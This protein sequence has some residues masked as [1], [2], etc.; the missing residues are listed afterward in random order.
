MP[1]S[2]SRTHGKTVKRQA[3]AE[4]AERRAARRVAELEP[5]PLPTWYK[6]IMFGLMIIGLLW[7]VVYYLTMGLAPIPQAGGWNIGIGFGIAVVGFIMT[8]RWR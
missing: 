8:T 4:Q 1:E 5:G 7:I 3:K 6:V 2:K